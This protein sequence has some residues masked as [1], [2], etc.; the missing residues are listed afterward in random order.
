MEE[1][2][3]QKTKENI[4]PGGKFRQVEN[5]PNREQF[6]AAGYFAVSTAN[7]SS[8]CFVFS[9]LLARACCTPS[10]GAILPGLLSDWPAVTGR[11]HFGENGRTEIGIQL[12]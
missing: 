8:T 10:R 12:C 2:G 9:T 5:G 3:R 11:S 7:Y 1:S 6:T 4:I